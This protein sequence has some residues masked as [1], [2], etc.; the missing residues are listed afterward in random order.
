MKKVPKKDFVLFKKTFKELANKLGLQ[1][2][3]IDFNFEPLED[4]YAEIHIDESGKC[5]SVYFSS[6]YND[7][8][9]PKLIA[10]HEAT[11]LLLARLCTLAQRRYITSLEISDEAEA[12][13]RKLE[14]IL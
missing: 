4:N 13:V 6:V 10:K 2:Y 12:I 3:C 7:H 14:N 11:H 5:A 9:D 1:E 8:R